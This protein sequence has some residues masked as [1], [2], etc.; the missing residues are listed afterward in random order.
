MTPPPKV[1]GGRSDITNVDPLSLLSGNEQLTRDVDAPAASKPESCVCFGGQ[2][3]TPRGRVHVFSSLLAQSINRLLQTAAT[4]SGI[5]EPSS[6]CSHV[7]S[8]RLFPSLYWN[9]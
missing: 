6:Y 5:T 1:S 2:S 3:E 7:I 4:L 8:L 9:I